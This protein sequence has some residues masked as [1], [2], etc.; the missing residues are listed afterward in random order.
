MRLQNDCSDVT[1][2][3]A[4]Y[5]ALR[6]KP[7]FEIWHATNADYSLIYFV[8]VQINQISR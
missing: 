4:L 6:S 2:I 7:C 1:D 8:F 3:T 5:H